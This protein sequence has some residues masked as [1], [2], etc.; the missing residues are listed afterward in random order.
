MPL[1]KNQKHKPPE[2]RAVH[3]RYHIF[4]CSILT[5]SQFLRMTDGHA[6]NPMVVRFSNRVRGTD[7]F[8]LSRYSTGLVVENRW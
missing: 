7:V 2:L 3:D 4:P 8:A 1:K 5:P 6:P